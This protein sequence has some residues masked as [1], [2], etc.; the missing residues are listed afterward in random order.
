MDYKSFAFNLA[1]KSGE[2]IRKNFVTGMQKEWKADNSPVTKTDLEINQLV[3]DS[4]KKEY[5][6]HSVI[7]E[8]GS[9]FSETSEYVWVCDPV[10]G[11]IPF[12]HG[13]PTC[14]FSLALVRNG[15]TVLGIVYDPF[16]D[17]VFFAEKGSGAFLNDQR[18]S[19]SPA[20]NFG[21]SVLGVQSG[22]FPKLEQELRKK[23]ARPFRLYS[24][25]YTSMLVASGEFVAN[26]F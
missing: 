23:G 4:V 9:D 7:A 20:K 11:T 3:L 22:R 12:S 2:I 10:D 14:A 15:E 18:I 25:I 16:M 24:T 17:R 1:R 19:V 6:D 8:E 21:Q 13:V 5:P 26:I